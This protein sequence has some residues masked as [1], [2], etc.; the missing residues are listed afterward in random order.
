MTTFYQ[1]AETYKL[2]SKTLSQKYYTD[3]RIF[4]QEFNKIFSKNW[5]CCGRSNEIA[6]KGSFITKHI[7]ND[8][9]LILRDNDKI[10]YYLHNQII[11]NLPFLNYIYSYIYI[12]I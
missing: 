2:G 3:N 11:L 7:G 1:T 5:L 9:I 8:S 10:N 6:L 4:Q 12:Y